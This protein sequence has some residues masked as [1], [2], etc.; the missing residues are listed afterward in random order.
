ML[1]KMFSS[2]DETT[3]TSYFVLLSFQLNRQIHIVQS[4]VYSFSISAPR[5]LLRSSHLTNFY[6]RFL[7]FRGSRT[8]L[9]EREMIFFTKQIGYTIFRTSDFHFV[10]NILVLCVWSRGY[11]NLF[12]TKC[13]HFGIFRLPLSCRNRTRCHVTTDKRQTTKLAPTKTNGWGRRGFYFG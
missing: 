7:L 12:S 2:S 4:A 11:S 9:G 6:N 8:F 13:L 3:E 10:Y 1:K 5:S